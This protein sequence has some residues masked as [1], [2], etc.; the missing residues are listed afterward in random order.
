M[1]KDWAGVEEYWEY[2]ERCERR[3]DWIHRIIITLLLLG[4]VVAIAVKSR[5][6]NAEK[7]ELNI[8]QTNKELSTE[9]GQR[10]K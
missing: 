5:D 7:A 1:N 4:I 6:L 3:W 9:E 2:L 8:Q 10:I